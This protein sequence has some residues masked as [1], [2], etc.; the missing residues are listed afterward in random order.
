MRAQESLPYEANSG[1][2]PII[3]VLQ[4]PRT[5][6]QYYRKNLGDGPDTKYPWGAVAAGG[7]RLG[8]VR[9]AEGEGARLRSSTPSAPPGKGPLTSLLPQAV[10]LSHGL[11]HPLGSELVHVIAVNHDLGEVRGFQNLQL[12]HGFAHLLDVRDSRSAWACL[13]RKVSAGAQ[14][15]DPAVEAP[16][17]GLGSLT[18]H[19]FQQLRL[20]LEHLGIFQVFRN[21]HP[22]WDIF[23]FRQGPHL[24]CL[25]TKITLRVKVSQSRGARES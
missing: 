9:R 19:G 17:S 8:G 2:P 21:F 10:P 16:E 5:G 6:R 18:K 13:E 20:D 23:P 12:K 22:R 4:V 11:E 15:R 1:P 25:E 3:V 7:D 24:A 14:G